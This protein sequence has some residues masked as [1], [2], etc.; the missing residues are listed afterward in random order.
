MS[1]ESRLLRMMAMECVERM[2]DNLPSSA[3]EDTRPPIILDT[4]G[5]GTKGMCRRRYLRSVLITMSEVAD[6]LDRREA[7]LNEVLAKVRPHLVEIKAVVEDS[8]E[9][10][11]ADRAFIELLEYLDGE[12][13]GDGVGI[14][15]SLDDLALVRKGLDQA[16]LRDE[17][18]TRVEA[19]LDIL[20]GVALGDAP[21][22]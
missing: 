7:A 22:S 13:L 16:C 15:F 9:S 21:S 20:S 11:A 6:R 4:S 10:D 5:R 19:L 3:G 1:D 12:A 2:V 14:A 8:G 17:E 18:W